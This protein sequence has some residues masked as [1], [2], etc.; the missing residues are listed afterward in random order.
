MVPLIPK[1]EFECESLR[2]FGECECPTSLTNFQQYTVT[3]KKCQVVKDFVNTFITHVKDMHPCFVEVRKPK[4]SIGFIPT[5][6]ALVKECLSTAVKAEIWQHNCYAQIEAEIWQNNCYAQIDKTC[7][8][9]D[10]TTNTLIASCLLPYLFVRNDIMH[11]KL[12]AS[13]EYTCMA[14][15]PDLYFPNILREC[16]YILETYEE[17]PRKLQYPSMQTLLYYDKDC[18]Y[19]CNLDVKF[20]DQSETTLSKHYA[21]YR[22]YYIQGYIMCC[23]PKAILEN[24]YKLTELSVMAFIEFLHNFH[25]TNPKDK[26]VI[27]KNS[28]L[29]L[30]M[31][32]GAPYNTILREIEKLHQIAPIPNLDCNK[33]LLS[34]YKIKKVY[35]SLSLTYLE[36]EIPERSKIDTVHFLPT[37]VR[38][39]TTFPFSPL[40]RKKFG[41]NVTQ[42]KSSSLTI[43]KCTQNVECVCQE[44]R[45]NLDRQL[46]CIRY[47]SLKSFSNMLNRLSSLRSLRSLRSYCNMLNNITHSRSLQAFKEVF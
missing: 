43:R 22:H 19:F 27:S 17:N 6:H 4:Y 8:L 21:F 42:K 12:T 35:R 34:K 47:C 5:D 26:L 36:E 39:D 23:G 31:L 46:E 24:K 18:T 28:Y 30:E 2:H 25:G 33:Y 38:L 15:Y 44:C 29:F 45:F 11:F 1:C 3:K 41:I 7:T 40:L 16:R 13:F 10:L 32:F 9:N 37:K 20:G 14:K